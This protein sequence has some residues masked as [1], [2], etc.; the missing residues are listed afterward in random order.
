MYTFFDIAFSTVNITLTLLVILL[1]AYWLIT[2]FSGID[3]DLDFDVDIDVDADVDIDIDTSVN[4]GAVDFH[5]IA[6]A[7]V[8]KDDIV[9]KR[10]QKLKWWQVLLIYFNFVGLPFM[11][12]FTAWIFMWWIFTTISTTLT[13]SLNNSFGFLLMIFGFFPALILTKIFTSPFKNFFKNLNQDGDSPIDLIGREGLCLSNI[14]DNKLGSAEITAEGN[15][16]SI[17][18]KSLN[19]KPIKFRAPI[20]VIK[21]SDDK[22]FYY[23]QEYIKDNIDLKF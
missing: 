13:H 17:N 12:T 8:N 23:V 4:G 3:F 7:E 1:V 15:T 21:Q 9:G 18:I 14:V 11:F 2:M 22:L 16:L 19:G 20:L 5:D 6:N 10:R